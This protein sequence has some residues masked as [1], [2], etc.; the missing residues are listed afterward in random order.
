MK[1]PLVSINCITY[2]H[3]PYIRQ[4]L[5]G[6]MMQKT[7]FAFEVLIHDDASTDNTANIIQ[8]YEAKY[9]EIIKPIY[10]AEN[11]YSKGEG[12]ISVRFNF[13]RAKGKYIAMCEGDDYWIDPHK[14]QKQVDILENN[15]N[16]AAVVTNVSVSDMQGKI[17]H[18]ERPGNVVPN[19]KTG[20]YNIHDF[21]RDGHQY[22]TLSV[23]FRRGNMNRTIQLMS[24]LQNPF[25]G[26]WI[27]WIILHYTLGDFY[28]LDQ[29]TGS[30]R[31]N[32]TSITHTANVVNRWK[33]DFEIR[34][35][36]IKMLPFEYHKYLKSDWY[37]Y[38]QIAMA[39]R[40][41][42][43]LIKMMWYFFR[44]FLSNPIKLTRRIIL[45]K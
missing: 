14:L 29:V 37:A 25:L 8:E 33:A 30:Y 36:L 16:L 34:K 35:Q 15:V 12:A 5:D 22:P 32:P 18:V 17:L 4:C 23:I 44:S 3:E 27:L 45:R 40:K 9:P 39:W 20:I 26:D 1:K 28:Y 2:N 38:F 13:P 10:Q 31:I 19:N 43:K 42:N 41:Q 7:N 11:Q 6:F 21:F 24:Q